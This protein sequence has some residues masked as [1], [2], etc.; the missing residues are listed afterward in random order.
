MKKNAT[1]Y[2]TFLLLM[3]PAACSREPALP[4]LTSIPWIQQY[5][6][7]HDELFPVISG[8]TV[9]GPQ[10]RV[11][12]GNERQFLLID[13]NTIDL[14]IKENAFPDADFEPQRMSNRLI[15]NNELMV[16][17]GYLHN[18]KLLNADFP[19]LYAAMIKQS[20]R[21]FHPKGIVGRNFLVNGQMT[22][23]MPNK[24]LAFSTNPSTSLS[25]TDDDSSIVTFNLRHLDNDHNG[26]L[27]FHCRVNHETV[28]AT[29][30]TQVFTTRISS[31]LARRIIPD[32]TP[33]KIGIEFIEIGSRK[34]HKISCCV[35]HD[36]ITLEPENAETIDI[37]IGMDIISQSLWTIDFINKRLRVE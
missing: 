32:K 16:E 21:P 7:G 31:E 4:D 12:A 30:S 23:D 24:L 5:G 27:K 28:L 9:P 29:I 26:L 8:K 10:I 17:E 6:Y 15:E 11:T 34:F 20:S 18:V 33:R 1:T 35:N 3:L 37:V 13:V 14:F 25:E 19:I 22:I 36:L 2:V